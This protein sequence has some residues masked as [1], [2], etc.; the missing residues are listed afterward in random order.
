MTSPAAPEFFLLFIHL[1]QQKFTKVPFTTMVRIFGKPLKRKPCWG[2]IKTN[3]D[4]DEDSEEDVD[5]NNEEDND[6]SEEEEEEK[7][8]EEDEED[9]A[10][11]EKQGK[12]VEEED[13]DEDS[14]SVVSSARLL[15]EFVPSDDEEGLRT[16]RSQTGRYSSVKHE[17]DEIRKSE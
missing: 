11:Q 6:E 5:D 12:D 8:E 10:E 15:E 16:L 13:E 1:Q 4:D 2:E 14:K 17:R 9:E 3:T 7:K